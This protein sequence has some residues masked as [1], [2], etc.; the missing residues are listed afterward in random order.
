M[1]HLQTVHTS[2]MVIRQNKGSAL[3]GTTK[4]I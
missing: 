3:F 4:T 2:T 1:G